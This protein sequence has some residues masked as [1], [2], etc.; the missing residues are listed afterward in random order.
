LETGVPLP[1]VFGG[2]QVSRA[3]HPE[4]SPVVPVVDGVRTLTHKKEIWRPFD[5]GMLLG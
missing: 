1:R 3:I 4:T 5:R 2:V